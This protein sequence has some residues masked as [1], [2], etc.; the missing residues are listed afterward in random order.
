M[1]LPFVFLPGLLNDGRLWHHPIRALG[2][3]HL[4]LTPVLSHQSSIEEMAA[5]VL[6]HAPPF[7]HLMGFSMGGYVALEIALRAPERVDKLAIFN[8]SAAPDTWV[9]KK[10]RQEQILKAKNMSFKGITPH[11]L[12][13]LLHPSNICKP[14]IVKLLY[15]MAQTIGPKG[16]IQ[17][18]QAILSK[19]DYRDALPA[20]HQKTLIVGSVYDKQIPFEHQEFL[21]KQ[22]PNAVLHPMYHSGHLSVLEEAENI[23]KILKK[24]FNI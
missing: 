22:I 24:F 14:H 15:D 19:I 7:F 21:S 2:R 17:Q 18:Q 16:F 6:E 9:K 4:I 5:Y 12:P 10:Y 1:T 13:R 20:I 3:D 11:L 8:S 23:N